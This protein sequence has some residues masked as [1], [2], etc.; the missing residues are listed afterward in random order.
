MDFFRPFINYNV[1]KQKI[2]KFN[3]SL[4]NGLNDKKNF[5]DENENIR[6]KFLQELEKNQNTLK[7]FQ[8][9]SWRNPGQITHFQGKNDVFLCLI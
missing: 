2:R 7:A 8:M 9:I 6:E 4:E 1:Q 3:F 5:H